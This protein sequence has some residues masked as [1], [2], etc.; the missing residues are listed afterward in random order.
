MSEQSIP[1]DKIPSMQRLTS[2]L[3][4]DPLLIYLGCSL[5]NFTIDK[6]NRTITMS[7]TYTYDANIISTW[8]TQ[9]QQYEETYLT[10]LKNQNPDY[11]MVENDRVI[12]VEIYKWIEMIEGIIS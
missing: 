8:K 5:S 7:E 1:Q 6:D 12:F 4:L 9:I 11:E 2:L 3:P 10:A